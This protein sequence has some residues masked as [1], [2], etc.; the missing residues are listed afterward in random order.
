MPTIEF[1]RSISTELDAARLW[2]L[3]VEAFENPGESP[4]W[5]VDLEETEPVEVREGNPITATYKIG[6]LRVRPSYHFVDVDPPRSLRYRSDADHPLDGGA[7]VRIEPTRQGATLHWTGSY[8]PRLHPMAPFAYLFVR[9]YFLD[10]FFR[11]LEANLDHL[12][13]TD[14]SP[15]A[16]R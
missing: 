2:Q 5:P 6:P 8:Q 7:T 1:D 16:R 9:L 11:R 12:A 15:R 14:I 13:S 4:F 10:T 3:L